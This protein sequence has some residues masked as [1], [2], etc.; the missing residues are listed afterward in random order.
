MAFPYTTFANFENQTMGHFDVETDTGARLDFPHYTELARHPH[1]PAPYRGA[2]CMRVDLSPNTNLA[3]V[4]ETGS[5]DLTAGTDEIYLRFKVFLSKDTVMANS[6]EFAILQ[7]WS[8]TNT[9]EA[10]VFINYTT[11][12]GFR[13]GIGS[14][15]GSSWNSCIL[16][17]WHD[18]EVYFNPAGGAGGAIDAWID[19]GALSQVGSLT[20]ANI[21]SGVLGVG[22][23]DA[24]TTKGTILFDQVIGHKNGARIGSGGQRFPKQIE[25]QGSGHVFVGHGIVDNVSLLSGGAA[26][27]VLR[28]W[29]TNQADTTNASMKLELK[30][31][32]ADETPIDPAGVPLEITYGC[33]IELSGTDPRAMVN[34][35][36]ATGY[37]SDGAVRSLCY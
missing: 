26:D 28:V 37:F 13:I 24:G 34:V 27:N 31:L 3:V 36:R 8:A 12:N 11:A 30:N 33:Y 16:G 20:N 29:D 25:V 19:R 6:D 2:Y 14:T 1:L 18:V 32:N 10:G 17:Q 9:L 15:T 22:L 5:W 7:F 35:Y 21:T 23:Q 4:Q